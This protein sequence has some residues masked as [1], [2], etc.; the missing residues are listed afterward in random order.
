MRLLL[1]WCT[2][3]EA[4]SWGQFD[5]KSRRVCFSRYGLKSNGDAGSHLLS[6]ALEVSDD[7]LLSAI[8]G[9]FVL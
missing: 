7:G 3:S 6:L 4:N 2:K 8:M 5:F 1:S 9:L